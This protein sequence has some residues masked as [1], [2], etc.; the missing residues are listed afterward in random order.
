VVAEL[1]M[2]ESSDRLYEIFRMLE[3]KPKELLENPNRV[4]VKEG[5]VILWNDI[6]RKKKDRWFFMFNDTLLIAKR[7]NDAKP[8]YRL[9]VYI[10]LRPQV[11]EKKKERKREREKERERERKREERE[12]LFFLSLVVWKRRVRCVARL[13]VECIDRCVWH[14]CRIDTDARFALSVEPTS[15]RVF[16]RV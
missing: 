8:K 9:R 12:K 13:S 15:K 14:T 3:P 10:T 5:P 2:T 11:R 4:F 6:E 1:T 7:L 16:R